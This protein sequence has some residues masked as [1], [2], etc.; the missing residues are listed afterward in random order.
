MVGSETLSVISAATGAGV[1]VL[2]DPLRQDGAR[3]LYGVGI[4][5]VLGIG[6]FAVLA[7]FETL[8]ET[9]TIPPVIAAWS[10]NA[11][12]TLFSAYLFLGVRS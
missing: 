6:M 5:V 11:L 4:A 3:A 9:A 12:F 1:G 8:G 7:V 10:P 2:C